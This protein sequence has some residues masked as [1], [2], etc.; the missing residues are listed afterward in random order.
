MQALAETSLEVLRQMNEGQDSPAQ[1]DC[2]LQLLLQLQSERLGSETNINSSNTCCIRLFIE[3]QVSR[4]DQMAF[5][6]MASC[7]PVLYLVW[8]ILRQGV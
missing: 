1:L 5:M 8:K 6:H 3:C 2:G 4:L 7:M